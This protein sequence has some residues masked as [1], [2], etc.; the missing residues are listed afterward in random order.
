MPFEKNKKLLVFTLDKK[1]EHP[2][3]K[4]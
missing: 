1:K 4:G 3:V 2:F